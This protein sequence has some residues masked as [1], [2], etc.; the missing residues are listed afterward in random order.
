MADPDTENVPVLWTYDESSK[1][2]KVRTREDEPIFD[3]F[4]S[5]AKNS[6]S[7]C[8]ACGNIIEKGTER[9][10]LPCLWVSELDEE[11]KPKRAEPKNGCF[12]KYVHLACSVN[13]YQRVHEDDP[14]M[15]ED[16]VVVKQK[17][18]KKKSFA[19]LLETGNDSDGWM[20]LY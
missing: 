8:R 17:S 14:F 20:D 15:M 5:F 19:Q 7:K 10:G 13:N 2:P 12:L 18:K 9:L 16:A 11:G 3:A 6:R 4:K 1:G